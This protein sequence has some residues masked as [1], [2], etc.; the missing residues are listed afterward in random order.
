VVFH[1]EHSGNAVSV[2]RGTSQNGKPLIRRV[3]DVTAGLDVASCDT[4]KSRLDKLLRK[5]GHPA[6]YVMSAK[7]FTIPGM[8]TNLS[9]LE[10][11]KDCSYFI[12]HT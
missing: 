5:P 10:E 12:D 8:R 7:R 6:S 1:V 2:P 11:D 4:Y 9:A 3:L